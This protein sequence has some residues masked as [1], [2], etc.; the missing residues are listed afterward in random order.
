VPRF[1]RIKNCPLPSWA[2]LDT[3]QKKKPDDSLGGTDGV[4]TIW[5]SLGS[6][7]DLVAEEAGL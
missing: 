4:F 3:N 5:I 6:T 2:K 1:E 7:L